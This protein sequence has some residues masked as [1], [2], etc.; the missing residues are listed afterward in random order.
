MVFLFLLGGK[1]KKYIM[2]GRM[3]VSWVQPLLPFIKD[4]KKKKNVVWTVG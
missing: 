2:N 3:G 1:A 4:E